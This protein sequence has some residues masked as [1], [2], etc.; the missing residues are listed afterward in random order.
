MTRHGWKEKCVNLSVILLIMLTSMNPH[1]EPTQHMNLSDLIPRNAGDVTD[2]VDLLS[3]LHA[4]ADIGSHSNFAWMQ[5]LDSNYDILSEADTLSDTNIMDYTDSISNIDSSADKGS[6]DVFTDVQTYPDLVYD[7]M[8]EADQGTP[9]N[10]VNDY[11]DNNVSDVDSS[12]DKGTHSSFTD[13]QTAPDSTYDTLTEADQ[14]SAGTN[15][16][17]YV[18]AISDLHAPDTDIGTHSSFAEMQDK[19][20][21]YD[22]LTESTATENT[23]LKTNGF[24]AYRDSTTSL[25]QAKYRY[26]NGNTASFNGQNLFD[27]AGSPIRFVREAY[28]T[29]T[30][31]REYIIVASISDDGYIDV[32]VW[33]GESWA[34]TNNLVSSGT[35]SNTYQCFDIAFEKTSGEALLVYSTGATSNEIGTVTWSTGSGWGT[36]TAFELTYTTG[37]VNWINLA[38]CS[39]LRAGSTDDDEIAMIYNDANVDVHGY[40]WTGS[41]WSLMG[42]S[43]VW[44]ASSAIATEEEIAVACE[45]STGQPMWI[46]ADTTS[47]DFYYRTYDGTTLSGPTLL[48]IT[49]A[50]GIGNWM[51]L[52]SNFV[53]D[54][55]FFIE[56]DAGTTSDINVRYWDGAAWAAAPTE[57]DGGADTGAARC[58]DFAWNTAGTGGIIIWGTAS[59]SFSYN[60]FTAPSTF[61]GALTV[62]N[63]GTHPW[64]A[65]ESNPRSISG[66]YQVMG[67]TLNSNFDIFPIYWTGSGAPTVGSALS[68]DTTV[69][70]YECFT[71]KFQNFAPMTP[72]MLDLE[73]G[74]TA[75]PFSETNEELCIFGGTQNTEA[76]K[77]DI[78]NGGSW[79]NIIADVAVGWNNVSITSYLTDA[80]VEI[81]FWDTTQ[82]W[83]VTA[84]TW[85]IEGVILHCWTAGVSDYELDLEI[86]WTTAD[87]DEI[88]EFLC[89]YGGT[90]D[91]EALKVDVR[92]GGS[93]TNLISDLVAGQWNNVSVSTYLTS[94]TITFRFVGTTEAGDSTQSSW[95]IDSALLWCYTAAVID[96]ELDL[97]EQ[98]TSA[99]YDETSEELCIKTGNL[100][101]ETLI[102]QVWT[103]SWMTVIASLSASAWNNV[104]VSSYLTSTTFTIRFLGGTESG[105]SS[106]STWNIDSVVLHCWSAPILYE[107]DLEVGWTGAIYDQQNEYLCIYGGTQGAEDLQVDVWGG[108]WI[109]II[110]DVQEGWNNVSVATYLTSSA[111]EIRFVDSSKVTDTNLDEWQIDVV[112]LHTWNNLPASFTLS[113]TASNPD[114]DGD[115]YLN[116][117]TST[118]ADNYSVYQHTSP[119]IVINGS[120]SLLQAG[121]TNLYYLISDHTNGTFYFIIKAVNE[122]G[123]ILSNCISVIIQDKPWNF[124][125]SSTATSPDLDGDYNLTWSSSFGADIYGVWRYTSPITEIN[126]SLTWLG[127]DTSPY[128]V[129]DQT[130][131]TWFYIIEASNEAGNTTSNYISITVQDGPWNF[132]L[133]ENAD[134]PDVDG[135]FDLLWTESDY[136]D[137]YTVYRH[138]AFITEINGSVEYL[139]YTTNLYWNITGSGSGIWYYIVEAMN[140]YTNTSS[141]C[142]SIIVLSNTPPGSF[143]LSENADDPD[144]DGTF[145]LNWTVSTYADNYTIYQYLSF[146]TEINGSVTELGT[147]TNLYYHVADY[148]NDTYYFIV[149]STNE[150][151]TNISNCISVVVQDPPWMFTV[152][153]PSSPDADGVFQLSWGSSVGAD[154][155]GV[156]QHTS[157]ISE[158]NG[159][160]TW[161]GLTSNTYWDFVD[162][163]N[164]TYYY[165]IEAVNEA[166]NTTSS[167]CVSIIIQDGPWNFILSSTV[168][169]PDQD[170]RFDLTWTTSNYADSYGVWRHT[171]VITEINASVTWIGLTF[172]CYWNVSDYL[173]GIYFFIIE[174]Q[175]E[176]TNTTS[177]CVSVTVQEEPGAFTLSSTAGNPDSDGDFQLQWTAADRADNYSVYQHTSP[178]TVIN[179]SVSLLQAS[180]TDLFYDILHSNNGTWYF[181]VVAFNEMGNTSSNCLSVTVQDP[182]W[183]FILTSTA[184]SPDADGT[185]YLNWTTSINADNYS[186]YQY[187]GYITVINGSVTFLGIT[188]NIFYLCSDYANTTYYFLIVAVNE[189]EN[190]SSNCLTVTVQDPPWNFNLSSTAGSPDADGDFDL[191]WS[192]SVGVDNYTVY[193]HIS[194]ITTINGTVTNLGTTTNRY[195]NLTIYNNATYYFLIVAFNEAGNVSSNCVTVIVQDPPWAFL[196]STSEILDTNGY[197]DLNWSLSFGTDNYS[198]YR[199]SSLITAINGSIT[200]LGTTNNLYWNL[201]SY[202]NGTYFFLIV[203]FNEA[204]N[205]SSNCIN[206]TVAITLQLPGPFLLTSTA[207][208]PDTDGIFLLT[209]NASV[210]A[211]NYSIYVSLVYITDINASVTL[212]NIT[213][214]LSYAITGATTGTFYYIV[215]ATNTLGSTFS[216]NI[217]VIIT[218]SEGGGGG[219]GGGGGHTTTSSFIDLLK[220]N[221]L[222]TILYIGVIVI[223]FSTFG[224]FVFFRKKK[225]KKDT[226][227]KRDK[228]QKKQHKKHHE[229]EE[230]KERKKEQQQR[231]HDREKREKPPKPR[232]SPWKKWQT[233]ITTHIKQNQRKWQ[234]KIYKAQKIRERKKKMGR[235][236]VW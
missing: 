96:Y 184:G 129:L 235:R 215:V 158:L 218:L 19:D 187:S 125:L 217:A 149:K 174:A 80:T 200:V 156:W 196:L 162:H 201:T 230:A 224:Y 183:P 208:S 167:N 144:P 76:L 69:S 195:W 4:P 163:L 36:P 12:A 234:R 222:G 102:V 95:E 75:A 58:A 28:G 169:S 43:A 220:T 63:A 109:N 176:Y 25:N 29:T 62:S 46:W 1:L 34:I 133:S 16:E 45:Y 190:T 106:Q 202:T 35:T 107:C 172:N 73:V 68:S 186:I 177:N 17:D 30:A 139:G 145:D 130:N 138:T 182:P 10:N 127:L 121:I 114:P 81:R 151:G 159:S 233:H 92:N 231:K 31:T 140:E 141:N 112:L 94:A 126:G 171:S 24:T 205:Q 18:D 132:I 101:A 60:I 9:G 52:K 179:G 44:D 105:D 72:S 227:K 180:I 11:V 147:T 86:Q 71:F 41:A 123:S 142:V 137:N 226:K 32:Y 87:Y 210:F 33:N 175:N 116:W 236:P 22:T 39:G 122:E 40:V 74:W 90:Q 78:W 5:L 152:N 153:Q 209:W 124:I 157:Y 61:G 170:G 85:E 188:T 53:N 8:L 223:A 93:W 135:S 100:D 134:D 214:G 91:A 146:I 191:T 70:T 118:D 64:V 143:I 38:T 97:E 59:G 181:L 115:F 79:A 83:D 65:L 99:D 211:D 84:G 198:I 20:A 47:T 98:W 228:H 21:I 50:G 48:D 216:N 203:A 89:I 103:G 213:T 173:A 197:F 14:G 199:H 51:T 15:Y 225:D 82:T 3:D 212:L 23:A 66:D 136:A 56:N 155:Y 13:Q 2:Y 111:L 119:I 117:T 221:L 26:W 148:S 27:T 54:D 55:L 219:G 232:V 150:Y 185:F 57:I 192:L 131:G 189:Y 154:S 6:H 49:S 204:G 164:G 110:A 160:L 165:R 178:I 193:Q 67:M 42:A 88:N 166:G 161:I 113:T 206:V 120:V 207:D 7:A 168:G 77:V 229:S 37:R 108:S 104:S 194:Y 128:N